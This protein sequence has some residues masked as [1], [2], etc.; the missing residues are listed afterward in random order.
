MKLNWK[1]PL[2]ALAV[3][4]GIASAAWAANNF[5]LTDSLGQFKTLDCTDTAGVC[6]FNVNTAPASGANAQTM[7]V[8]PGDAQTNAVNAFAQ[9]NF[10][11]VYNGTNWDRQRGSLVGISVAPYPVAATVLGGSS[12]NVA[13]AAATV[14]LAAAA[15]VTTYITG[16]QCTAAGAT[17]PLVVTATVTGLIGGVQSHTFVFPTG[18]TVVAE[19]LIVTFPTPVPASAANTA[20]VVS[21][22]AGG[23][24]NTNATCSAQG[25]RV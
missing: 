25:F 1:A 2:V 17:A 20:I 24:G 4:A 6:K 10:N 11:Y 8:G 16:F 18:A 23:A 7:L 3:I 9:A 12:G 5:V 22:P 19:P 21:L 14:T 13:N 15:S